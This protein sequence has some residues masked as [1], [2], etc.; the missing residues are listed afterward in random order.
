MP[1][2]ALRLCQGGR[3]GGA[4]PELA[5]VTRNGRISDLMG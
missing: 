2:P 3:S 1:L 4:A 5:A